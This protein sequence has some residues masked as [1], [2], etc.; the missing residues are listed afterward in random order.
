MAPDG[1]TFDANLADDG[2]RFTNKDAHDYDGSLG[3]NVIQRVKALQLQAEQMAQ[4]RR[5]RLCEESQLK[6]RVIA[7]ERKKKKLNDEMER[8]KQLVLIKQDEDR[9]GRLLKQKKQEE[10]QKIHD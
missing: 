1:A 10:L 4:K 2:R 9:L 3:E 5:Q 8:K 7:M 6:E